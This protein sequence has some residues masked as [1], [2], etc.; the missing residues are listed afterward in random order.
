MY[1]WDDW[2]I[3]IHSFGSIQKDGIAAARGS[4]NKHVPTTRV[5]IQKYYLEFASRYDRFFDRSPVVS[6]DEGY[7][8]EEGNRHGLAV[9]SQ[10]CNYSI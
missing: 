5:Q 2:S 10:N 7:F 1:R 6:R 3:G 4:T 9:G 8:S